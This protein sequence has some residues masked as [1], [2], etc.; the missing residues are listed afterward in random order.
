M[1]PIIIVIIIAFILGIG[2]AIAF[3]AGPLW[4]ILYLVLVSFGVYKIYQ[5]KDRFI[6]LCNGIPG[7]NPEKDIIRDKD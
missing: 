5:N 7:D 6:E 2:A 1:D 3:K 4:G